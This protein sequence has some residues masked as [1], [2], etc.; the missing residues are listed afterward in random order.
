METSPIREVTLKF[1]DGRIVDVN[2]N[3][4]NKNGVGKQEDKEYCEL[5][6]DDILPLVTLIS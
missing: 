1:E 2:Y 4:V 5:I 6:R 3:E